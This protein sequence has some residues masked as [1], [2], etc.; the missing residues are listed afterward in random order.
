MAGAYPAVPNV[1]HFV[2]IPPIEYS[3]AVTPEVKRTVWNGLMRT[4][5]KI[6]SFAEPFESNLIDTPQ[7]FLSPPP[8]SLTILANKLSCTCPDGR[9]ALDYFRA[10]LLIVM[11]SWWQNPI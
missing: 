9:V 6:A 11:T 5:W 1:P 8:L 2:V 4:L 7:V 3:R 10:L